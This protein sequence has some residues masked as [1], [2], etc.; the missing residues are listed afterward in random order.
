MN[1]NKTCPSCKKTS[2]LEFMK[3]KKEYGWI[4]ILLCSNCGNV[5]YVVEY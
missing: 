2:Y 1:T 4:V 3:V 5:Y